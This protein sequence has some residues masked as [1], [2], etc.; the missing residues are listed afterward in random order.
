VWVI[1]GGLAALWVALF[2]ILP[3]STASAQGETGLR[4]EAVAAYGGAFKYG[5]WLPVWVALENTGRDLEA[6]VQVLVR[7]RGGSTTYAVQVSLP[8]GARKRVPIYVLPNNFSRELEVQVVD[9][10]GALVATQAV[11][12]K[13][14]PNIT[15]LAGLIAPERGALASIARAKPPDPG[16]PVVLVSVAMAELPDRMAAMRSFDALVFNDVDSS[17][18]TPAQRGALEGWVRQGGRLVLGGG[19]GARS[20]VAGLPQ[21]L[22]PLSPRDELEVDEL[23]GLA[24]YADGERVRVQGPFLVA[25]GDVGPG[26]TLA[27]QEG[28]PLIRERVL[29][30]GR[31]AWVALDLAG[32]PFDAWAGAGR[33]WERLLLSDASFPR[34]TPADV[35]PREM[36]SWQMT[37][38]LSNLPSLDLPSIR[39]LSILLAIYITIVGPVNYVVLRWRKGLQWAWVTVPALTL[40]FSGSAFALGY[41]LRGTDLILNKVVLVNAQREGGALT[42]SYVGLFSPSRQSYEIEVQG[43]GLL[44][45]IVQEG[46]PFGAGNT[47]PGGEM[48]FVQGDPSWVR[49]LA[50]NQWSMQTFMSEGDWP[51]L[52]TVESD[53][54][55]TEGALVGT[56]R[57]A[58][59]QT[60]EDAVVVLGSKYVRLGDLAPGQE[61]QVRLE[62]SSEDVTFFGPPISYRLF[63]KELSQPGPGGPPRDVQ[64]KQQLL[65]AALSSNKYS[66]ISSFR[67]MEV[68]NVR[69]LTLI[70]WL[71]NAP[72]EV[73][74]AGRQPAQQTTA[75]YLLPL[76][77]RLPES[78]PVSI[79]PGFVESRVMQMP[80]EGGP[81]GPSGVPAV[82]IGRGEAIFEFDLPEV[83][84]DL[85]LDRLVLSLRSEGGWRQAPLVALYNWSEQSWGE[86]SEPTFGD[87]PVSDTEAYVSSDGVVRVR[88]AVDGVS[89]GSCYVVGVGFEGE[90]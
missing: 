75:L 49:G 46:D 67:P 48:T 17:S 84:A 33:F 20:T 28:A 29:G 8:G 42:D 60:L 41:A 73:R 64:L 36:R 38:A 86:L 34:G 47:A 43:R 56:V 82:Y 23:P 76:D 15:F 19:A 7:G 4:L 53:L 59:G 74:V 40:L 81:C 3:C 62:L 37:N 51:E 83:M 50:I 77:Y 65:D 89:G 71:G 78:G 16:R 69:G 5:E 90:K 26:R 18:L 72:P 12:V 79:P 68:G 31:V 13:G 14:Y 80:S 52:G 22:L 2:T 61:A 88:L 27:A 39:G 45:P 6:Q 66:P 30:T 70:A 32:T 35:S 87:N 21:S 25:G 85:K 55:F 10:Q 44:S 58:T 57:N 54:G 24:E 11:P 63:E 1:L 9:A